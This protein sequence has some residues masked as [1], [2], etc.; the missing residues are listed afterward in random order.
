MAVNYSDLS[1][2][3]DLGFVLTLEGCP[4]ALATAGVSSVAFTGDRPTDW[5]KS[6]VEWIVVNGALK[7]PTGWTERVA[8]VEPDLDVQNMSFTVHDVIA[9]SGDA[10]GSNLLT[11]L[12]SGQNSLVRSSLSASLSATGT[13]ISVD[14][15]SVF[16]SANFNVWIDREAIRISSRSGNTLTVDTSVAVG[17]GILGSRVKAHNIDAD[18]AYKPAIF[19]T[20]PWMTRRRIVLWLGIISAS[21]ALTDPV[22]E[23]KGIISQAPRLADDGAAWEIAADYVWQTT[24]DIYVGQRGETCRM[25]GFETAMGFE[26]SVMTLRAQLGLVGGALVEKRAYAGG[27]G[28]P[29]FIETLDALCA[30]MQRSMTAAMADTTSLSGYAA[31]VTGQVRVTHDGGVVTASITALDVSVVS[32]ITLTL[33]SSYTADA[34]AS[35]SG[36]RGATVTAAWPAAAQFLATLDHEQT[37]HMASVASLPATWDQAHGIFGIRHA[38]SAAHLISGGE[39]WHFILDPIPTLA[40]GVEPVDT[41]NRTITGYFGIYPYD[42]RALGYE[43]IDGVI[44]AHGSTAWVIG[45]I[46]FSLAFG[47][48]T[49]DWTYALEKVIIGNTFLAGTPQEIDVAASDWDW[50]RTLRLYERTPPLL[51]SRRWSFDGGLSLKDMIVECARFSGGMIAVKRGAI[52]IDAMEKPLRSDVT[53]AAHTIVSADLAAGAKPRWQQNQEGIA[54]IVDLTLEGMRTYRWIITDRGSVARYGPRRKIEI[55][56]HG[57]S[58]SDELQAL[59]PRYIGEFVYG[60]VLG[61]WADSSE[62]ARFEVSLAKL[63]TVFIGDTVTVTDWL[64]PNAR[65]GRGW[66]TRKAKVIG[67]EIS[68]ESGTIT[69]DC[70]AFS[71]TNY[72]GFAPCCRAQSIAGAAFTAAGSYANGSDYAGS[73]ETGYANATRGTVANDR[74]VGYFKAGDRVELIERDNVSPHTPESLII[75]SVD[76]PST[77]ITFTTTPSADWQTIIAGGGTVDLRYDDYATSGL[78]TAQK[79]WPFVSDRATLKIGGTSDAAF[80]WVA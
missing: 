55:S 57:L 6:T 24:A 56:L 46:P 18:T 21:G 34:R 78:Q 44:V 73:D 50:S 65:R 23:W 26:N 1:T 33:Q 48:D 47:V 40:R 61:L 49:T 77:S 52:T 42:F 36:T 60:R 70:L 74:G 53:D 19:S 32:S 28:V 63:D 62:V 7:M 27:L 2:G 30:R 76:T 37:I 72:S 64:A 75:S 39:N 17:R 35:A 12:G 51:R 22:P 69:L 41:T 25:Q 38:I 31:A 58:F 79:D 43:S 8:L 10:S 45:E 3:G 59:G 29:T 71:Q 16:G 4:Y 15:G 20:F 13:S 80:L 14:D 9:T 68:F 5:A 54:N 11:Y 67:R 66:S